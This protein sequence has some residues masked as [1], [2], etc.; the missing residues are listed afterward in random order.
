MC[1]C[2]PNDQREWRELA[3]TGAGIERELN[4]WLPSAARSGGRCNHGS[5]T[6]TGI[7][8]LGNFRVPRHR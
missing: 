8:T 2:R 1:V 5:L 7:C 3:A 4:G 6:V